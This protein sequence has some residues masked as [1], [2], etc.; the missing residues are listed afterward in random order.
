MPQLVRSA[1]ATRQYLGAL[2]S[3]L[4]ATQNYSK[5]HVLWIHSVQECTGGLGLLG[6]LLAFVSKNIHT[7]VQTPP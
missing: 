5:A 3:T 7:H 4:K 1:R 2:V 6:D